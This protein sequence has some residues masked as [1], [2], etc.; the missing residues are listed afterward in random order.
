MP[1]LYCVRADSGTFTEHFVRGG[2]AGI[3]WEEIDRDLSGIRS[4]DELYP[5]VR[6]AFPEQR[7]QVVI[8]NYVGQIA[9]FL[10]DIKASDFVVT[11][12]AESEWLHFGVVGT[13]PSYYFDPATDG[14]RYRHRRRVTW[15]PR[16]LRRTELSV[17]FQN[18]MRSM[19]TVFTVPHTEEFLQAIGAASATPKHAYDA[20]RV[21][22]ER[23]LEL[24]PTE[25]EV[26]LT[27]LLS[28]IGFE[29]EHTGKTGDG[30]VDARGDLDIA[31]MAKVKLYVQAKRFK[32]GSKV[33]GNEVKKLRQAIPFG[34]QGAF[35]TTADYQE[36]ARETATEVGFP[37]IGLI[38]GRQ[39]VD[40]LVQY[41]DSIPEEFR[42]QLDLKLGLV[43]A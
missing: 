1:D 43:R 33:S 18:S 34:G 6:Q 12:A 25:F 30:G 41:W 8:G 37:R 39:L 24:D 17:P 42:E 11:P 23:L 36:S 28:A 3:G 22:L 38:N 31:G 7:Y 4:K 26:F 19:L 13:D 32:L 2:Y 16:R 21:V 10:L 20:Y 9:R 14:C 27:S 5:L 15:D 40:L 35:I 29:A